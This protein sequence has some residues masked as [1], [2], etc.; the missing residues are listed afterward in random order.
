MHPVLL[1]LIESL[2]LGVSLDNI[3]KSLQGHDRDEPV[4]VG[5][6]FCYDR[7]DHHKVT[8]LTTIRTVSVFSEYML[9]C[10]GEGVTIF[11]F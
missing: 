10:D 1:L 4:I 2:L 7:L 8:K 9:F 6:T 11:E 5:A 3:P